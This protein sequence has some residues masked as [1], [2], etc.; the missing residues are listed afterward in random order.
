MLEQRVAEMEKKF[1]KK[2]ETGEKMFE[3][4]LTQDD[5]LSK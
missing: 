5:I 2:L 4:S 1:E 3:H